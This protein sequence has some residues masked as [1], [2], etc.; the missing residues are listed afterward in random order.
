MRRLRLIFDSTKG[1]ERNQNKDRIWIKETADTF[2]CILFDG[3]SSAQEASKGI[4]IAV[5]F[6]EKNWSRVLIQAGYTLADLMFET[7]QAILH[8]N[9]RTPFTTYGAVLV[10][11]NLDTMNFSSLG[12]TR[13]YRVN[14]QYLKQLSQDDNLGNNKNIVTKYLGMLELGRQDVPVSTVD[15]S[16]SRVLLCSDGFYS[17]LEK[18]LSRF[19]R[20]LNFKRRS[21]IQKAL[22][23]E[24]KGKNRDDSSYILLF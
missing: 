10:S 16:D 2:F 13:I 4:D 5:S 17:L 1:I 3:I 11:K 9:L 18:D 24:V 23:E 19:F 14:S 21:D 20:V 8:S 12:D 6:L 7:N 15:I 22:D